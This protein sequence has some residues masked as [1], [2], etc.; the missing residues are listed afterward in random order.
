ML[1]KGIR[2]FLLLLIVPPDFIENALT[3]IRDL[4][5]T[6]IKSATGDTLLFVVMVLTQT[7]DCET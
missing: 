6:V 3:K 5:C 2:S 7:Y 4:K 1:S